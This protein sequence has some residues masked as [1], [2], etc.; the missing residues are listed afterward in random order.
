MHALAK[1]PQNIL[2]IGTANN[3][4]GQIGEQ[5]LKGIVKDHAQQTQ[6]RPDSFAQQCAL[7]EYETNLVRY[8]MSELDC[9]LGLSGK[10]LSVSKDAVNPKGR[11]T[12]NM[13]TTNQS[14]VG[15]LP[16]KV[17]GHCAM[18]ERLNCG[19]S[20]LLTFA[21]RRHSHINGYSDSF[22]VTGYTSLTIRDTDKKVIYYATELKNGH[23]QYDYALIDFEGS[24]GITECCPSLI[25]GFI[26]YDITLGIPT[27]QFIQEEELSLLD[28]QQN[29]CTN[30][31]LY[32]V[33]HSASDYLPFEQ[34][35]HEFVSTFVLGDVMTCLY[36]E[37]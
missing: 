20:D 26:R 7:W 13:S 16:D 9:Q 33:V 30:N 36:C 18:R 1:M 19:V 21:V 11:Y 14:G 2:K 3:F 34:L 28:I 25:L 23:K 15:D 8:V 27:P 10:N 31:S 37:D 4:C 5:A 6:R 24:D 35:Q 17:M 29:M 12:L 22:K 32:A